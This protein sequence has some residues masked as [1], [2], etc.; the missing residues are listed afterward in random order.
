MS[1]E[2]D[3]FFNTYLDL[4][5]RYRWLVIVG[6]FLGIALL[7]TGVRH[8]HLQQNYRIFFGP[9]NPQLAAFD[10]LEAVY[11][12]IDTHIFVVHNPKGSVFNA[13]AM[14][15]V[16]ELTDE[17]WK[18]PH[19]TRV[20]S[21]V[22]YQ[23]SWATEDDLIVEDLIPLGEES[24]PEY[25]ERAE[26]V[27]MSEPIIKGNIV[28]HDG[29]TTV[30]VIRVQLDPDD[31]LAVREAG[32][33]TLKMLL[34]SREDHPELR[35]E[36][37]GT[38]VMSVAFGSAP[39]VDA[40]TVFP[41]MFVLLAVF[42]F[43]FTRS[44]GG[45][46]ATWCVIVLSAAGAMG[47]SGYYGYGI[48][49]ANMAAPVVVLTLA[50][51]DSIHI[52]LSMFKEM[53]KGS[54]KLTA[55]RESMR[56]NAQPIFLT[57]LT[58][59]IGFLVMNFSDSPPFQEL[60]NIT[61]TGVGLAWLLSVSFLPAMLSV[62]PIHA[63]KASSFGEPLMLWFAEVNIRHRRKLVAVVGGSVVFFIASIS[64]MEIDDT[65]H[66]YFDESILFRSSTD[67]FDEQ[68]GF[69]GFYMSILADEPG[70]IND[71]EY[72]ASLDR[73]VD[74]LREQKGVE[75]V[76]AYSEISK[77]L[78]MNMHGDDPAYR[79]VPENRELAAQYLLL[80][81]MSLPLGMDLND[82]I[83]VDKSAT[84]LAVNFRS[85]TLADVTRV[86]DRAEE[87]F[88]ENAVNAYP[89][90]ATGPPIMFAKITETNI[91]SMT[92]G[93]IFGFVLIAIILMVSL[94]SFTLGL[95]SLIPN[96]VPA[97]TA[98]GIWALVVGEAGFAISV[99]A[100]LSIGIIVDDTV[101]F[102]SKYSRARRELGL[103]S[104][105]A[106]RYAFLTVGQ[107]LLSTSIIVAGGFS[108]LMLSTFRVTSFMGALT[109]LT[110]VCALIAD[111]LLLPAILLILDKRGMG[112]EKEDTAE[113][114]A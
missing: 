64:R 40:K 77:K 84:R 2:K 100:G 41:A 10:A 111:F 36:L 4:I 43:V 54:D 25:I 92:K 104:E 44:L 88:I 47:A 39:E 35:F 16:R 33:A 28:S 46:I 42:M 97:A 70:G 94:R 78:N 22:N 8:L 6:S 89:D 98:F 23:H 14:Q 48:N 18:V 74:W 13:K 53:N 103:D 50:I 26:K 3:R 31:V 30:I 95:L 51:A 63:H 72:L 11:T 80:Y 38:G 52:L 1:R 99:V 68:L 79:V 61:A 106:V 57:S 9:D 114:A 65:P 82:Q 58:T 20:D 59:A 107:A 32:A 109:A 91:K 37:S 34:K 62:L 27:S 112:V 105:E 90:H 56:I 17:G 21:I 12:K 101:H 24:N 19:S 66:Q 55:L 73:F 75:Y 113:E 76:G 96:I 69:Y 45:T 60:G 87:W 67:F 85:T 29:D 86:G 7:T 81:E 49:P 5:F 102:L 15:A 71:P 108:V 110:I 83:N 93:T